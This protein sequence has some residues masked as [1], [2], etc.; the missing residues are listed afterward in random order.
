M[1]KSRLV[2]LNDYALLELTYEETT[3]N[4]DSSGFTIVDNTIQQYLQVLNATFGIRFR[5]RITISQMM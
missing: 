5:E 3:I 1:P 4:T 2:K